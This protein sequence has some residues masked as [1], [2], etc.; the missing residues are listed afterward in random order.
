MNRYLKQNELYKQS[1]ELRYINW[2][3]ENKEIAERNRKLQ[4]ELFK[5]QQYYKKLNKAIEKNKGM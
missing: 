3:A 1:K 5:K 4:D 2:N